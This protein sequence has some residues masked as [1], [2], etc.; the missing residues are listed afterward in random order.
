M[1]AV[2]YYMPG[3]IECYKV[4]KRRKM[5]VL[6]V[7]LCTVVSLGAAFAVLGYLGVR[8]IERNQELQEVAA[9]TVVQEIVEKPIKEVLP[10]SV[11]T[12]PEA[13]AGMGEAE[14][15]LPAEVQPAD[16]PEMIP[17]PDQVL[18]PSGEP[19]V[20]PEPT[21]T[22]YLTFDDGP[23]EK[24]TETILDV[25][26]KYD[27]KATFFLVGQ[28][29]EKNPEIAKRI[30]EEGHTIGIH[31]YSHAYDDLYDSVDGF[32]EDF[33]KAYNI[34]YETTG[35]EVKI[36]R[37]PGGSI[38]A[39]N[40]H[41]YKDIITEMTNRGFTYYDWNA[42]LE[43]SVRKC[44]PEELVKSAVDTAMNRDRVILLAHDTIYN[45]SLCIEDIILAFP[46]YKMEPL[47]EEVIPI[48]F[49]GK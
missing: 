1:Y 43:D 16:Q 24:Y 44:T 47:T 3:K 14:P 22:M 27:I 8:N 33:E 11:Q 42:S 25:L 4:K 38:N 12:E 34:I 15:Q 18:M 26:A 35:V 9:E 5:W 7:F 17:E 28:N 6:P 36:F 39:Y 29:V 31:C 20:T 23:S 46:D 32:V 41:I 45:T 2:S 40:K 10:E 19:E 37:F 30:V 13:F 21:K 49:R 48:C